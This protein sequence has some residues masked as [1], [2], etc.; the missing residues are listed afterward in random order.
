LDKSGGIISGLLSVGNIDTASFNETI[1]R[2]QYKRVA[3]NAIRTLDF[4][5]PITDDTGGDDPFIIHT[6][7]SLTFQIDGF[8]S[9]RIRA[10]GRIETSTNLTVGGALTVTNPQEI[11]YKNQTLDTRFVSQTAYDANNTEILDAFGELSGLIL[12]VSDAGI[13]GDNLKLDKTGGTIAGDLAVTGA[14]TASSANIS[15]SLSVGGSISTSGADFYLWNSGRGG[16]GTSFGRALVHLG[17][18]TKASSVLSINHDSDFGGGTRIYGSANITAGLSANSANIST[19]VTSP[20]YN[21]NTTDSYSKINLYSNTTIYSI[22]TFHNENYGALA[23][24]FAMTFTMDNDATRGWLWRKTQ[25][26]KSQ[27]TMSLTTSGILTVASKLRVGF[28]ESD[29]ETA[30]ISLNVNGDGRISNVLTVE[31]A[32]NTGNIAVSSMAAPGTRNVVANFQ[33]ILQ[34]QNSDRRLKE[35]IEPINESETHLKLLK[36]EPHTYQWKDREK[37]GDYREIGL[38]AQEVKEVLPQLVF[39][40]NDGMYGLHYDKIS[41]LMLQSIKQLQKQIDEL[42]NEIT[43][44][45]K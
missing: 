18:A 33:G 31:N 37:N 32:I 5:S 29:T 43:E 15:G 28:G 36:L 22:G 21:T 23:N 44:L 9:L 42:K 30:V 40:N 25:H 13:A 39:E 45:R 4:R 16:A 27:G 6:N 35:N 26:S 12:N 24:Q 14:L 41:I 2:L 17:S 10:N 7:N 11:T 34:S 19:S 8:D 3:N 1:L 38:I 20:T